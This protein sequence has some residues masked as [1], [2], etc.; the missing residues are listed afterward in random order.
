MSP[1]SASKSEVLRE[2]LLW[3]ERELQEENGMRG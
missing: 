2:Y 1:I 3:L